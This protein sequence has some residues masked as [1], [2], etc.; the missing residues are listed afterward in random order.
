MQNDN[1]QAMS[2]TVNPTLNYLRSQIAIDQLAVVAKDGT[3]QY[4]EVPAAVAA[5]HKLIYVKAGTYDIDSDLDLQGVILFGESPKNTTLN[6]ADN[7]TIALQG[8]A[9][10]D[11]HNSGDITFTQN[12]TA[13]TGVATTWATGANNPQTYSDPWVLIAN[14]LQDINE[15]T[16]DTTASLH[17]RHEGTTLPNQTEY[18]LVDLLNLGSV[19]TGFTIYDNSDSNTTPLLQISDSLN[20]IFN[21]YFKASQTYTTRIIEMAPAG[22]VA[23]YNL[24]SHN[25][26]ISGQTALY[27]NEAFNN[28]IHDNT[29][30]NQANHCIEYSAAAITY[31]NPRANRITSNLL[32][33]C[34]GTS[35]ELNVGA[36]R[37]VIQSNYILHSNSY[38]IYV[39]A[40]SDD[41]FILDNRLQNSNNETIFFVNVTSRRN[42]ISRNF[43]QGDCYL[44]TC[45]KMQFTHNHLLDSIVDAYGENSNIS[46]NTFDDGKIAINST[47]LNSTANN[48]IFQNA[49]AD[50]AIYLNANYGQACNNSIENAVGTA[51]QV[52]GDYCTVDSN[53]IESPGSDGIVVHNSETNN[54]IS[55]NV[56][57]SPSARGIEI[58]SSCSRISITNNLINGAGDEGIYLYQTQY[59]IVSGNIINSPSGT[60]IYADLDSGSVNNNTIYDAP[61]GIHCLVETELI[62]DGNM[63]KSITTDYG[64]YKASGNGDRFTCTNNTIEDTADAAIYI[65]NNALSTICSNNNIA[66]SGGYGI[67]YDPKTSHSRAV[68][69]GNTLDTTATIGIYIRDNAGAGATGNR[70]QVTSNHIEDANTSA[71][72]VEGTL[73]TISN[74]HCYSSTNHGIRISSDNCIIANNVC[75]NNGSNGIQVGATATNCSLLGN[76]S[77]NNTV[78][79]ILDAGTNTKQGH[80]ITA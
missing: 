4:E 20:V 23:C 41:L 63:I 12:S 59:C 1:G 24:I 17:E 7:V 68:F 75:T 2:S 62:I 3:G 31:L 80:N 11:I 71:I 42:I 33:G 6:V 36:H 35:I 45:T 21:N 67:Y 73:C 22:S 76:I 15:I 39:A 49:Q 8:H 37:T 14:Y 65:D 46:H 25:L 55:N 32:L 13:V 48:N 64:I 30:Q 18:A 54:T 9:A 52:D 19:I 78:N 50:Y 57:N 29:F 69:N 66:N 53:T 60:A 61:R 27:I 40:D 72:I 38:C 43:I 10:A 79:N 28:H 74:N 77:L 51:I 56:I 70:V 26:F 44:S 16:N 34:G 47:A 58:N 5:G